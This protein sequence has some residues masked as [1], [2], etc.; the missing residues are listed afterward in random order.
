MLIFVEYHN[1][2]SQVQVREWMTDTTGCLH[3]M[4]RTGSVNEDT[5]VTLQ[6]IADLGYAWGSLID[7][8]T[9][10]M[11][12]LIKKDPFAVSKLRAVFLKVRH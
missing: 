4:L 8:L 12:G 5:L 7:T 2:E 6:I 3:R 11:Q 10:Q 1:L 9:P